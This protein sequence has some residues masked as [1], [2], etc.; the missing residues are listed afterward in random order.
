MTAGVIDRNS[1]AVRGH[2]ARE[3]QPG[4]GFLEVRTFDAEER[5][6]VAG[7]DGHLRRARPFQGQSRRNAGQAGI[8]GDGAM[9]TGGKRNTSPW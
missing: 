4:E 3:L 8:E 9:E 5:I 7:I 2:P 1:A 6:K